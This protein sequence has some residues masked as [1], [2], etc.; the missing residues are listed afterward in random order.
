[1]IFSL[2]SLLSSS[3]HPPAMPLN[4]FINENQTAIS[5]TIAQRPF[6]DPEDIEPALIPNPN[7]AVLAYDLESGKTLIE[8]NAYEK[9]PIASLTKLMT[10]LIILENHDMDE[11]VTIPLEATQAGG[12]MIG[13]Y[14]HE[15]ITVRTLLEA[16]LIASANDAAVA[17]AV[18][19]AGSEENF[20]K[21]MNQRAFEMDLISGEFHN[22]S[23]L[24]IIQPHTAPAANTSDTLQDK[25][26]DESEFDVLGNHM[27]AWDLLL[28]SRK[29]WTFE[30]V[31]G[32]VTKPEF[33]GTSIDERFSHSRKNTNQLLDSFLNIKGLKT[34][35]TYLAGECL[36]VIGETQQGKLILSIIL[37][38]HDRFGE[39][40]DI[41][42]WIY[43][44]YK[45]E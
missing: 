11:V 28:L 14:Q 23:G 18:H 16:V 30:F 34:G 25:A 7:R 1:M 22:S 4:D 43:D 31:R 37:G 35:F 24:D 21:H 36:V 41:L 33:Y 15:K 6:K 32:T 38:S 26:I 13:L 20:V 19:H 40:T 27:S 42:S 44:T 29:L 3:I 45:W 2:L 9:K 17:L 39:T 5:L 12:V 8:Q 10:A